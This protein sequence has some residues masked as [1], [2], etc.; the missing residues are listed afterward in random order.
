MHILIV[1]KHNRYSLSCIMKFAVEL[2]IDW[3]TMSFDGIAGKMWS[4]TINCSTIWDNIGVT[5][6]GLRSLTRLQVCTCGHMFLTQY[7]STPCR[8][9]NTETY[10]HIYKHSNYLW[11]FMITVTIYPIQNIIIT[12]Q[13]LLSPNQNNLNTVP[14]IFKKICCRVRS[15]W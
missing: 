12:R 7:H 3:L 2:P 8:W 5:Y 10:W 15:W 6:I 1:F 11:Q 9:Y 13:S 14:C 4:L